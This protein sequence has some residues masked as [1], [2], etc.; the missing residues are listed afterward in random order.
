MIKKA[1]ALIACI[2]SLMS[3]F[4]YAQTPKKIKAVVFDFG[5]IISRV[6][7]TEIIQFLMNTFHISEDELMHVLCE[8]KRV[9]SDGG[10]EKN[11]W[12]NYAESAQVTLTEDWFLEYN[13]ITGFTRIPFMI[14]IIKSLQDQGYQTPLLSNSELC[15]ANLIRKYDYYNLFDPVLLSNEKE[16]KKP[17]QDVLLILLDTLQLSPRELIFIEDKKE[18][19]DAAKK[20]GIDTIQFHFP[21]QL[22]EELNKRNI[23]LQNI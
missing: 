21:D 15:Q 1:F 3:S 2:A 7:H 10:C 19:I 18:H 13:K 8:W 16:D 5:D 12:K 4:S 20:L 11:F 22:I 17:Q 23:Y 14:T 6:D 9:L